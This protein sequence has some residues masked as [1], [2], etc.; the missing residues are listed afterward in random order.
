MSD[1]ADDI[2]GLYQR[3]A[4]AWDR[5]RR[6]ELILERAWMERLTALL[7]PGASMLD[8]GCGSGQPIA[9]YLIE[10]GYAVVGVDSSPA[11]IDKCRTRFPGSEWIVGDMCQLALHRTFDA[12]IA[13]DS[14]FHLAH[15]HQRAM[16]PIFQRH[17]NPGG[18]LLLTTG[19]DHGVAIGSYQGEPLYHASLSI[20]E[21]R[22]LLES[23]GF[24]VLAH[25]TDDPDCGHHGVWLARRVEQR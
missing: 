13:W 24:S 20:E 9:K 17:A 14:F 2:V 7:Q 12:I 19:S 10:R 5:D 3:H 23:H 25:M 4:E 15:E 1:A 16:F 21:Y 11:L 8:V 22:T 18:L 6:S